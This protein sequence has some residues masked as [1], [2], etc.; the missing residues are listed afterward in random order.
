MNLENKIGLAL[1]TG[2]ILLMLVYGSQFSKVIQNVG[3][4]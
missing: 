4:K 3:L 1:I 2:I